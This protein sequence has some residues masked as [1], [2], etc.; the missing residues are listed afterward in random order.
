M[1]PIQRVAR[2]AVI[3]SASAGMLVPNSRAM[4]AKTELTDAEESGINENAAQDPAEQISAQV[5]RD[6][7]IAGQLGDRLPAGN[8]G[9]Y[10]L[11][12]FM[13]ITWGTRGRRKGNAIPH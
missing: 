12:K 10:L 4:G 11:I 9:T 3:V 7:H 13:G 2:L 1:A 6:R 5:A 8:L